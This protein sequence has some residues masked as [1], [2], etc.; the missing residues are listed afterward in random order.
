M[1]YPTLFHLNM[2]KFGGGNEDLNRAY[3]EVLKKVNSNLATE[4]CYVVVGGVTEVMNTN[5]AQKALAQLASALNLQLV[6]VVHCGV[7]AMGIAEYIGV[8]VGPDISIDYIG[9]FSLKDGQQV[10]HEAGAINDSRWDSPPPGSP[11]FRALV[12]VA[13]KLYG[14]IPIAVGF[15]H[16]TYTF[17]EQRALV[18]MH[19]A[20]MA[21]TMRKSSQAQA[22]YFGGDFNVEPAGQ[23]RKWDTT[24]YPY[25][26]GMKTTD[27][28]EYDYWYSTI[29]PNQST[30]PPGLLTPA[31]AVDYAPLQGRVSDHAAILLRIGQRY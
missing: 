14:K 7:S 2:R 25:S 24:I 28:H 23:R 27:A 12:Y 10:L 21:D 20:Q 22:V 11:D 18:A 31:A 3:A 4:N 5:S 29:A 26:T 6:K 1:R 13:G 15:I 16:N 9:R 8:F 17:S 19:F 30:L